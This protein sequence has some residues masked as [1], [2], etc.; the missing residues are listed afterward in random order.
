MTVVDVK[1]NY[2]Y[3]CKAVLPDEFTLPSDSH[4][5]YEWIDLPSYPDN[6]EKIQL[7]IL[8]VYPGSADQITCISK[9][10]LR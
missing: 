1:G 7:V 8:S 2:R 3:K 5:S 9:V 10:M 4:E 6:A